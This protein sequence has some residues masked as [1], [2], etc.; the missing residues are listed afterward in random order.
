MKDIFS[1]AVALCAILLLSFHASFFVVI[2]A[3]GLFPSTVVSVNLH[4]K[5]LVPEE[6]S[7]T[8]CYYCTGHNVNTVFRG[9]AK[10]WTLFLLHIMHC[11]SLYLLYHET[12]KAESQFHNM[13]ITV[14]IF[15]PAAASLNLHSSSGS[16]GKQ[17]EGE[18]K[19]RHTRGTDKAEL[20]VCVSRPM[21]RDL[22]FTPCWLFTGLTCTHLNSDD[23][24]CHMQYF[25]CPPVAL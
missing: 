23:V 18:P 19:E 17:R 2:T 25:H 20:H 10:R 4:T 14:W 13:S 1:W 15:P 22:S 24:A 3:A 7:A 5:E 12:T 9:F 8:S 11:L 21:M 16:R 6:T